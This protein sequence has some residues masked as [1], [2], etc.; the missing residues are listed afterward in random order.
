MKAVKLVTLN[1]GINKQSI[2]Q[3][4]PSRALCKQM[5]YSP[6]VYPSVFSHR[7]AYGF[8]LAP[9]RVRSHTDDD[10]EKICCSLYI[11]YFV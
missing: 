4:H 10:S 11:K 9:V 6:T 1:S 3:C 7:V 5:V 8:V 2:T